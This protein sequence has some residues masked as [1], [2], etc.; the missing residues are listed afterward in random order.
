MTNMSDWQFGALIGMA[1]L[2]LSIV[3]YE[4]FFENRRPW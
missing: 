1:V 4:W 2:V 3:A